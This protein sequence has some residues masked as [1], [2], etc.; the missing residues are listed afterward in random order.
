MII[1]NGYH[2]CYYSFSLI[3][4]SNVAI[5]KEPTRFSNNIHDK[6]MGQQQGNK[7]TENDDFWCSNDFSGKSL[8][9]EKHIKTI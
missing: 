3:M 4:L 2:S 9:A 5:C 1:E 6:L 8:G 7:T